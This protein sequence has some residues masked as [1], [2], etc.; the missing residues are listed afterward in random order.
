LR[1]KNKEPFFAAN[2][3]I[4][5]NKQRDQLFKVVASAIVKTSKTRESQEVGQYRGFTIGAHIFEDGT[6]EK[7]C[8]FS[9]KSNLEGLPYYPD[10]LRYSKDN[11]FDIGGFLQRLD[12]FLGRFET[13][14]EGQEK[15]AQKNAR[16]LET[17]LASRGQEFP[18]MKMLEALREDNR[19]V[20]A[21]LRLAQKDP[22]YKSTWQP[23]SW[24]LD[25]NKGKQEPVSPVQTAVSTKTAD[26]PVLPDPIKKLG[27]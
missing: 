5:D 3:Q 21:E 1:D 16:E 12:N 13:M 19:Q 8:L 14:I 27:R 11:K 4:Y 20:M 2:G 18:H 6:V 22:A 26:I 24:S 10:N 17:A 9:V 7:G 25:D 23:K 15:L